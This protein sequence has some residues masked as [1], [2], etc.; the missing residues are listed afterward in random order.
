MGAC[1]SAGPASP[2]GGTGAGGGLARP[3]WRAAPGQDAAK[4]QVR[5]EEGGV[6]PPPFPC[7]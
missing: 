1:W 3:P 2:T 7:D 4:V 6:S 5:R